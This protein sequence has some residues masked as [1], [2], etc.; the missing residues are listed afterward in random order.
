MGGI[1]ATSAVAAGLPVEALVLD[2]TP[3]SIADAAERRIASRGYPLAL[4]ASWAVMLGTLFRTGVD[5]TAA[6]PILNIDDVGSVP[7]LILQGS[8]D[9]AIAPD[10]G[11]AL[12]AEA[13]GAGV[14]AEYRE[15]AG[16]T[17]SHLHEACPDDFRDWVLGFL[18]RSLAP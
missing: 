5:I 17:H 1:T 8:E 7:V 11:A 9:T 4:P 12:Q 2:S 15:C 16:A 13:S 18:S 14:A 6:D 3:S 10:A